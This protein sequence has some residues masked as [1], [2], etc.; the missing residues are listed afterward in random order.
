MKKDK[1]IQALMDLADR[2]LKEQR[3]KEESIRALQQTG[4]LDK[5]GN[6]APEY[7]ELAFVPALNP[8][9]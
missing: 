7:A 4:I 8:R 2:L 9:N 6:L 5:D 1:Q 3:T